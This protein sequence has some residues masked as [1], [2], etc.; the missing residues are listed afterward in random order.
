MG[1]SLGWARAIWSI[2]IG[3][4]RRKG[5]SLMGGRSRRGRIR[6]GYEDVGT[7]GKVGMYICGSDD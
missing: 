6:W 2:R 7:I 3:K 4:R 5:R 1:R